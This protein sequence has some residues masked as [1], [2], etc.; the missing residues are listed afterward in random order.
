MFP[1]SLVFSVISSA[2]DFEVVRHSYEY[3][4]IVLDFPG[5]VYAT[6]GESYCPFL[7][8]ENRLESSTNQVMTVIYGGAGGRNRTDMDLSARW[9]LSPVRLPVSP[10]R[11]A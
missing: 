4:G 7:H 6:R 10:R 9:I 1:K 5:H 11:R 2:T 3:F 8:R